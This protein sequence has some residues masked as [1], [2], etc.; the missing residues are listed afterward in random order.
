MATV[1]LKEAIRTALKKMEWGWQLYPKTLIL[2]APNGTLHGPTGFN[3]A[4]ELD[5]HLAAIRYV[6][7][8]LEA[9]K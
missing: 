5:W 8:Q 4:T 6:I 1:L 3:D 9:N 7:E 2:D